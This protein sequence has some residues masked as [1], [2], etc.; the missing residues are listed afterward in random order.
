[1]PAQTIDTGINVFFIR[2]RKLMTILCII[3][4][5]FFPF[6]IYNALTFGPGHMF[7]TPGTWLNALLTFL[8]VPLWLL[9]HIWKVNKAHRQEMTALDQGKGSIE[10]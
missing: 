4:L 2:N 3:A 9:I 5:A 1:M 6:E 8:A 7:E 10:I